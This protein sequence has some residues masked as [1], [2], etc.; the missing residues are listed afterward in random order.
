MIINCE[1]CGKRY[2]IDENK[3]KGEKARLKC[4]ACGN[5]MEITKPQPK[6]KTEPLPEKISSSPSITETKTVSDEEVK[7]RSTE[8]KPM[9]ATKKKASKSGGFGIGF[10]LLIM[11]IAFIVILG[12]GLAFVYMKY[13]PALMIEQIDL[14]TYSISRSLSSAVLEPLLV[15]NYLRVN[16]TAEA[17]TKLPGVAYV[18]ILNKKGIVIAGIFGDLSRFSPSFT[19]RV[20]K[21][22]FARELSRQIRIPKGAQE[23]VMDLTVGSQKIR[24]VAVPIEDTGGQAHVGLF[25]EDVEKAVH[26][27]MIPLLII[28]VAMAILG[29]LGFLM[30]ARTISRPIRALTDAAQRISLGEIDLPIDVKGGGEIADLA[31]SLER[32]RFS[33]KAAI[34]RLK[35]K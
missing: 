17:I 6:A 5:I 26:D 30:I 16:Q 2:R 28:L 12:S 15:R 25:T 33:I 23:K 24:V 14:R 8:R 13:V 4:K 7:K 34:E 31:A 11:F 21:G 10:K 1:E 20:K 9:A 3:I 29:C 35:R 19:A 18:A 22:G 27:S 32:M